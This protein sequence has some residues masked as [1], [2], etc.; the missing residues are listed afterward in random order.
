MIGEE[1]GIER[2]VQKLWWQNHCTASSYILTPLQCRVYGV[3]QLDIT[4]KTEAVYLQQQTE[5]YN[6]R[7]KIQ[8][9]HPV[10]VVS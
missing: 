4:P 8:L 3:V 10:N 7:C 9:Y 1:R 6:L 2:E 5:F